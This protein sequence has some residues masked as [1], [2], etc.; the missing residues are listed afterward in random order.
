M[1]LLTGGWNIIK[2]IV[3]G[4]TG[5][6]G[7]AHGR[8]NMVPVIGTITKAVAKTGGFFVDRYSRGMSTAEEHV[9]ASRVISAL[10]ALQKDSPLTREEIVRHAKAAGLSDATI[11]SVVKA[12]DESDGLKNEH[13]AEPDVDIDLPL[14]E[15]PALAP[16]H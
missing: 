10:K 9:K 6:A 3:G 4:V 7:Y 8:V 16:S 11:W 13:A 15:D 14:D 2:E 5:G 1:G 12:V